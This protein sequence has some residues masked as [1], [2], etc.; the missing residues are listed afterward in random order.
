MPRTTP[1]HEGELRAQQLSGVKSWTQEL[2]SLPDTL[3]E[4]L[5][6]FLAQQTLAAAGTVDDRGRVWASALLGERG[7][8]AGDE[9]ALTL[10]VDRMGI[11]PADPFWAGAPG[12]LGVGLVAIH[13]ASRQ[14][15]RIN[16][17]VEHRTDGELR[18]AVRRA[19]PEC[20]KYIRSRHVPAP[21]PDDLGQVAPPRRG[22]R[23]GPEQQQLVARI[24]TCFV[25]S[26]HAQQG[27]D[28]SHRGGKPGFI[29]QLDDRTLRFP[30]YFGNG[31]FSTLG[32][33]LLD[34]R[35]GL[36]LLDFDGARTLQLTGRA[37][38]QWQG[39]DPQNHT[40]GTRRFWTFS[41]DEWLECDVPALGR[42]VRASLHV[43][44]S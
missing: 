4:G 31:I 41:I 44:E 18:I 19:Y 22:E 34:P 2:E 30:D 10:R 3:D 17:P 43:V 37:E 13:L 33:F 28:A 11:D 16:G 29:E 32:N 38:I 9:R 26:M 15:V 42:A 5:C 35:A 12:P 23:L 39:D 8:L 40:K 14:R 36:V 24:E 21:R 7:F 25:A 20:P 1:Y 6:A 27:L